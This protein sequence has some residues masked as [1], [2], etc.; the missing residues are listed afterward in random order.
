[1]REGGAGG[2]RPGPP[3]RLFPRLS[4]FY[5]FYFASLGA[6]VP[7]W[8]L[9]LDAR[10]FDAAA[11]GQLMG[12]LMAAKVVAPNLWGWLADRRERRMP[13]VRAGA[14]GAAAAFALLLHPGGYAW[15]AAAMLLF[16]AFW[17][18]CLPQ[19]EAV[20]FGHLRE[21]PHAYTRIRL[22]GS[23]GF[24]AAVAGMGPL[25]ERW[26]LGLLPAALLALLAAIALAAW[27]V[28]EP[29][30]EP[31][32]GPPP[33]PPLSGQAPA[34]ARDGLGRVLRQRRVLGLL[35]VC[36]LMQAGHGPYYTFFSLYLEGL[37]HPRWLVGQLWALGVAAEVL[38]F[39]AMPALLR[40]WSLEGLLLAS[41]L[42]AALRWT[43]VAW[44]AGSLAVLL[45]AQ[46]LHAATFGL[47][48]GA[49]I[50]LVHR[51]FPG[52]LQG[53]GQALYSSLSFGA[54]GALGAWAAGA[55]WEGLGPAWTYQGAA[56]LSLAGAAAARL[57]L[58]GN[59]PSGRRSKEGSPGEGPESGPERRRESS[60]KGG[61]VRRAPA[62][63]AVLAQ[64][65]L[66]DRPG[67]GPRDGPQDAA[68]RIDAGGARG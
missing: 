16:G 48:H 42:L 31:A 14:L 35:L 41:L 63:D 49:A 32:P 10:G 47:Y 44:L 64:E 43:L 5:F 6:L 1:M 59:A 67:D 34:A 27:A 62:P 13:V 4:L 39:L 30:P 17:Q 68:G 22:W 2:G 9:Y 54:G 12:L 40:R 51:L 52:R 53:R 18:A 58:A 45:L 33:E 37:G 24:I 21:R 20:T 56:L 60:A 19:F 26:G 66:G 8:A 65:V 29:P 11:I 38:L 25:L 46:L 3:A 61:G 55:L 36:F 28:P 57:L 50:Q 15:T 23:L 7:Y